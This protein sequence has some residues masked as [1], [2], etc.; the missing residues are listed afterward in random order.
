MKICCLCD[1]NGA[2]KKNSHILSKFYGINILGCNTDRLG[3]I[4]RPNKKKQKI[5]DLPK[6]DYLLCEVCESK[7]STIE[8]HASKTLVKKD[9]N[10]FNRNYEINQDGLTISPIN[11][12]SK[13]LIVFIY[14]LFL[15]MH[16]SNL[17][18][19]KE[20]NLEPKVVELIKDSLNK[21]LSNNLKTTLLNIKN[22]QIEFLSVTIFTTNYDNDPTSN[23]ISINKI[24][25]DKTIQLFIDSWL[26]NLYQ[27]KNKHY[28]PLRKYKLFELKE[29]RS[30]LIFLN[31][32][33]W[34]RLKLA[35]ISGLL[36]KFNFNFL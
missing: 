31:A 14:T 18:M 30:D 29:D 35:Y 36:A 17:E 12:N 7:I 32:E 23:F 2:D 8:T 5:Q 15:R 27:I 6:E 33:V 16:F 19:F 20:V 34:S 10:D 9:K 26:I 28:N 21:V 3:Y 1:L 4:N 25:P 22:T 11:I 13:E 24:E